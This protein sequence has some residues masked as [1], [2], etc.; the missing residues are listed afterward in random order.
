MGIIYVRR[1][2]GKKVRKKATAQR[3][4]RSWPNAKTVLYAVLAERLGDRFVYSSRGFSNSVCDFSF[5]LPNMI[6]CVS[7]SIYLL[8]ICNLRGW[9]FLLVSVVFFNRIPIVLEV[10]PLSFNPFFCSMFS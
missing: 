4:A 7:Y 2:Q 10:G 9:L 8:W 5:D 3:P 1:L 6:V